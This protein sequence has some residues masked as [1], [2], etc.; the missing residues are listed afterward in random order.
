MT[1]AME[2]NNKDKL[3]GSCLSQSNIRL[4]DS[5]GWGFKFKKGSIQNFVVGNFGIFHVGAR[6]RNRVLDAIIKK[7]DY[8]DRILLDAGCGTGLSSV[9]FSK[10]FKEVVG[11]DIDKYKILQARKLV[12]DC[13]LENVKFFDKSLFSPLFGQ[14]KFDVIICFE[15][16][17]HI[18]DPEKLFSNFYKKLKKNG[19]LIISFP[20][21]SFISRIA[22]SSLDHEKVGYLPSDIKNLI[23]GTGLKITETYSFGNTPLAKIPIL[24]DF[25]FKKTLPILSAI[26]FPVFYSMVVLD[27]YLPRLGIPRGYVLVLKRY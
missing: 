19:N 9:F 20:T 1:V 6:I 21:R 8:S 7:R 14:K 10:D 16:V 25:V 22:Q 18:K 13:G 23:E 27:Y 11:I 12:K 3:F 15:V 4:R 17:E 26:F 2:K 5:Y 24:I